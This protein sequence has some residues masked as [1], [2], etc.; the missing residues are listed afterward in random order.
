MGKPVIASRIGGVPEIILENETGWTIE[1]DDVEDWVN[2]I[3]LT[4]TD[5]GLN[6]TLG[7]KGRSW[8]KEKFGWNTVARQVED[9]LIAEAR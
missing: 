7:D 5:S 6:K 2:K 8:V 3:R 1:N 4:V 9:I